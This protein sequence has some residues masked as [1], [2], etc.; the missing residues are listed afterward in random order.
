MIEL[1]QV[2]PEE[3]ERRSLEIITKEL[4]DGLFP[5]GQE[6]V[7]KRVSIPP[8]ILIMRTVSCFQ[9]APWKKRLRR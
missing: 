9:T 5:A 3:I 4:G 2:L 8:L 1:E 7:V 6:Q